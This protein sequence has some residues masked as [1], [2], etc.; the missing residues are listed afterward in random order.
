MAK[1]NMLEAVNHF[2]SA[3]NGLEDDV[4]YLT[5][6][7]QSSYRDSCSSQNMLSFADDMRQYRIIKDLV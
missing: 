2:C 6:S 7:S 4:R 3:L 1:F 5:A